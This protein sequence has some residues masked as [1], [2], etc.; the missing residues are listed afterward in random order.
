MSAYRLGAGIGDSEYAQYDVMSSYPTGL[1]CVFGSGVC[2]DAQEAHAIFDKNGDLVFEPGDERVADRAYFNQRMGEV[3]VKEGRATENGGV[4]LTVGDS[5]IRYS[6][7]RNID[8]IKKFGVDVRK[9]SIEAIPE[10]Y[11]H[12]GQPIVDE[13]MMTE[14][15]GLFHARGSGSV[16]ETG[17]GQ[18]FY[19]QI[20]GPYAGHCASEYLKDAEIPSTFDA[21]SV[22]AEYDRL[23]EIRTRSLSDGIRPHIIRQAIQAAGKKALGVYRDTPLSEEAI[24][25][26]EDIRANMIPKMIVTDASPVYNTEWKE[27]IEAYNMLDL[28]EMSVR[29]SLMRE[30]TRGMYLRGEFPEKDDQNWACT[31]VARNK[32]GQ[33]DFEKKQWPPIPAE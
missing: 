28:T 2:A 1:A 4:V 29:A 7:E 30:E 12:G 9:E 8:L 10:M 13:N 26:L 33:M 24:A 16:G 32:N 14:F 17:G 15:A 20:F 6:N 21:D 18:V 5:H 31:L 25:E 23:Q 3:L 22:I 11:E 27:A 19:N